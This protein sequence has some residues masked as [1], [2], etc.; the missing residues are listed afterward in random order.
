MALNLRSAVPIF[1]PDFKKYQNTP[2]VEVEFRIGKMNNK[3]FD[4]NVGED[5]F[6]K[7]KE[8]L[9]KYDGWEKIDNREYEV[10]SSNSSGKRTVINS[11]DDSQYSEIKKNIS[12]LNY[13]SENLPFDVRM[14]IST[15]EKCEANDDDVFEM[16]RHMMRTSYIRKGLSIDL[17]VVSGSPD[18]PDDESDTSYQVEF[19]IVDPRS[20]ENR[21]QFYNHLHKIVDLLKGL[22]L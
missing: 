10:F 2:N 16:S 11:E 1:E 21:N 15:E 20:V 4:T 18:D 22:G 6:F 9:E 19:E 14:S 13:K 17:T 8:Y 3:Y 5:V 7:L 12:K